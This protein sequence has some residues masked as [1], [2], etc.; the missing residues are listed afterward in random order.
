MDDDHSSDASDESHDDIDDPMSDVTAPCIEPS[1]KIVVY[2]IAVLSVAST[3]KFRK[4]RGAH[5][6]AVY[7]A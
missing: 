5:S 4:P 7:Y 2:L 3:R 1:S 6:T